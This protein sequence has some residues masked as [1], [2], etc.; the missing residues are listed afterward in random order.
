MTRRIFCEC[1]CPRD[2]QEKATQTVLQQ[3][4]VMC[5]GVDGVSHFPRRFGW[6]GSH[7]SLVAF[8]DLHPTCGRAVHRSDSTAGPL[9]PLRPGVSDACEGRFWGVCGAFARGAKNARKA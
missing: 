9:G 2:K 6:Q 7:G 5:A 1:G 3:P 8:Q 4:G